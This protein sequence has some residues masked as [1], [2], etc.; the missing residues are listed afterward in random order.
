MECARR[1]RGLAMVNRAEHEVG[2]AFE[3][4]PITGYSG[5]RPRLA[6][7]PAI[8]L[9][10]F[11]HAVAAQ[12]QEGRARRDFTLPLV[13]PAQERTAAIKLTVQTAFPFV[14]AVV[15]NAT[16]HGMADVGAAAILDVAAD[17]IAAARIAD[18]RYAR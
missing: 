13:Q 2:R 4:R 8:G 18:Q 10:E 3:R 12:G 16:Q 6:D 11:V 14:N 1:I 5:R 17:R 15:G 9:R 7:E